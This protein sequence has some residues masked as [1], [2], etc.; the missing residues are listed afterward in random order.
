MWDVGLT[1]LLLGY[2]FVQREVRCTEYELTPSGDAQK[3]IVDK[4][5]V[6]RAIRRAF[7]LSPEKKP[8][9]PN[10]LEMTKTKALRAMEVNQWIEGSLGFFFIRR[11]SSA[12]F[13]MLDCGT[14]DWEYKEFMKEPLPSGAILLWLKWQQMGAFSCLFRGGDARGQVGHWQIK[15]EEELRRVGFVIKT[16]DDR[17][18]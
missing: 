8:G 17:F 12:G 13:L 15:V 16:V 14:K 18:W 9:S 5:E 10:W 7:L 3:R 6:Y 4:W 11:C 2:H 1:N